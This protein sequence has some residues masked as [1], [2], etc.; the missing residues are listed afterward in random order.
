MRACSL[1]ALAS[2]C[3]GTDV[4]TFL[5][6]P[7]SFLSSA[8]C[9]RTTFRCARTSMSWLSASRSSARTSK[10]SLS[11]LRVI[12]IASVLLKT[13]DFSGCLSAPAFRCAASFSSRDSSCRIQPGISAP[14]SL[15]WVSGGPPRAST[16]TTVWPCP[17]SASASTRRPSFLQSSSW[18]KKQV[19]PVC[20]ARQQS[21]MRTCCT[22]SLWT[23]LRIPSAL[24]LPHA[25]WRY[26][27]PRDFVADFSARTS[28]W[29]REPRTSS[30]ESLGLRSYTTRIWF[31]WRTSK[32]S[33]SLSVPVPIE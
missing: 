3:F 6:R 22:S 21:S 5:L 13:A 26:T 32:K 20:F 23:C 14:G 4:R 16:C 25:T 29:G 19:R 1:A 28:K 17:T 33:R 7:T 2:T 15:G 31:S 11:A 18:P 24:S 12:A 9:M 30:W 27:M 10:A 8:R